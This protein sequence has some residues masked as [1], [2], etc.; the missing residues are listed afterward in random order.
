MHSTNLN[1][2]SSTLS[3]KERQRLDACHRRG[4]EL[5]AQHDL[6]YA[7]EM[8]V[9]C[10]TGDPGN[11][12][13][14]ESML[15]NLRAQH[16]GHPKKRLRFFRTAASRA[17]KNAAAA[18]DHRLALRLAI[19][20]LCSDPW[21]VASLHVIADTCAAQHFNA[22]EL[23]YLKQALEGSPK[24]ADV[25]RHCAR[26]L[27]RMGQF[28][29]AIACWH[30]VEEIDGNDREAAEMISRL[31]EEKMKYP[32]G[33]PPMRAT[34]V[35]Q[36]ASVE[37]ETASEERVRQGVQALPEIPF[38]PRQLVERAIEIDPADVSNYLKLAE[39][40]CEM[41]HYENAERTLMR[42]LEY[43]AQRQ[44]IENALER[45]R[46]QR[47]AAEWEAAEIE[48]QKELR[49][50]RK[51]FR[52]PWLELVLVAAGMALLF[53]FMPSWWEALSGKVVGHAQLLM[54]ICNV[55]ALVLLIL[56]RQWKK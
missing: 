47:R 33:K 17:L 51:G 36:P 31:A 46:S 29:Q 18:H 34:N 52:M 40:L 42:A 11:L 19:D 28:D 12:A 23:A 9:Q 16:G 43:C 13:Y 21:H 50:Q 10:V 3:A 39:L 26:S 54:I 6:D 38:S 48:R 24:D 37:E 56:C 55:L 1:S 5:L 7:H 30:R 8:F 2:G 20:A 14:V 44:L 4:K 53:Q 41:E 49:A 22:V 25:N 15:E 32:G 45:V 27:A 35:G